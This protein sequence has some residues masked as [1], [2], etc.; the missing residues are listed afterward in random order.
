MRYRS[1]RGVQ[2]EPGADSLRVGRYFRKN[3]ERCTVGV[4]AAAKFNNNN[5]NTDIAVGPPNRAVGVAI[6]SGDGGVENV[7]DIEHTE[8]WDKAVLGGQK[9]PAYSFNRGCGA[10]G[11]TVDEESVHGEIAEPV[12]QAVQEYNSERSEEYTHTVGKNKAAFDAD[13]AHACFLPNQKQGA[14]KKKRKQREKKG[15]DPGAALFD[16]GGTTEV[17][18]PVHR[19]P[20]PW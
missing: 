6:D 18:A 9:L 1:D 15:S 11:L 7:I 16:G 20:A 13:L 2:T 14:E 19:Q 8:P 3:T 12:W 5:D 17:I 10:A 4:Q